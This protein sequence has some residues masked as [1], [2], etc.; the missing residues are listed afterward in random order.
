MQ[1]RPTARRGIT[2]VELLFYI[3]ILVLLLGVTVGTLIS[4]SSV[5]RNL[6]ALEAVNES[7]QSSLDRIVRE[8]RSATSV[9]TVKSTL[10]SS[11]G[12]L[13]LNTLD[14]NGATTT[15]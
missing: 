10:G 1:C 9:D 4:L 13:F 12:D 7:S 8:A 2:M 5:Y 11:P 15:V 14:Q 6:Q 3:G